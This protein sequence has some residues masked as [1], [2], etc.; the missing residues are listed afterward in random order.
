MYAPAL[1]DGFYDLALIEKGRNPKIRKLLRHHE[2]SHFELMPEVRLLFEMAYLGQENVRLG[3]PPQCHR[4][5]NSAS[6]T[7]SD[8]QSSLFLFKGT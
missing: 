5:I 4:S 6:S 7:C 1:R 3:P 2:E 8:T